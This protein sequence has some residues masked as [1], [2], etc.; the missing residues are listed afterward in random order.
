MRDEMVE[1]LLENKLIQNYQH[2]F[3]QKKVLHYKLIGVFGECDRK[4]RQRSSYV[5][6]HSINGRLLKWIENWLTNRYQRVVLNGSYSEWSKVESGVPQ[7]SVLG[8]S[9]F[10][11][12]IND[13]DDCIKQ[14]T[15]VNKFADDTKLR[16][17]I[18]SD[19][20]RETL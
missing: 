15:I 4:P 19:Q 7:G 9:A 12:F 20:D 18:E 14:L 6:A 3:M 13:L 17:K 1:H 10:V 8:P 5:K 2:G 16:H 11:I